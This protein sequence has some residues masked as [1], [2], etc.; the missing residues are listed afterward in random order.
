MNVY[1]RYGTRICAAQQQLTIG[2]LRASSKSTKAASTSIKNE[3]VVVEP[4]PVRRG[5]KTSSGHKKSSGGRANAQPAQVA[6]A[7][8]SGAQPV[9]HLKQFRLAFEFLD[10]NMQNICLPL[11]S[12]AVF[13]DCVL[14]TIRF[15]YLCIGLSMASMAYSL[16]L[17]CSTF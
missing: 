1:T 5:R 15:G 8:A 10:E 7:S 4:E 12:E 9:N 16:T 13:T 17:F 14:T 3:P 2:E 11:L 6:V